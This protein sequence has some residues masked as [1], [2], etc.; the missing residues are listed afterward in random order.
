MRNMQLR[1]RITTYL[2][3]TEL[4]ILHVVLISIKCRHIY[5]VKLS[6]KI[7]YSTDVGTVSHWL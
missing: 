2:P 7:S 6:T 4:S 3:H 5:I 1:T